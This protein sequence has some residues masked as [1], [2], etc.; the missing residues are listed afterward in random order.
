MLLAL[1]AKIFDKDV[2]NGFLLLE[3]FG[4]KTYA[5]ALN[6]LSKEIDLTSNRRCF[7]RDIQIKRF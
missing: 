6:D 2:K 7:D 4:D 1:C 3:D 5:T